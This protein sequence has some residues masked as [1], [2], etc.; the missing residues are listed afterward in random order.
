M[1]SSPDEKA[2]S[3]ISNTY[4]VQF[5]KQR[6]C[7]PVSHYHKTN[8]CMSINHEH[9]FAQMVK[10]LCLSSVDCC[11]SSTFWG[12]NVSEI[13]TGFEEQ[14]FPQPKATVGWGNQCRSLRRPLKMW[15]SRE[16]LR[17]F[18]HINLSKDFQ[19]RTQFDVHGAH[20]MILFQEQQGLTVDLLRTELFSDL[21]AA[22]QTQAVH[23]IFNARV[24]NCYPSFWH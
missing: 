7:K 14:Q 10:Y 1:Q 2:P 5:K 12:R 17:V 19:C 11:P 8:I 18:E 15:E 3:F 6:N 21:L 13:F 4:K 23:L 9:L 16:T 22:W 24:K 20:E